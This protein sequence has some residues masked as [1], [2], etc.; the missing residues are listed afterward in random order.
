VLDVLFSAEH[1]LFL[2]HPILLFAAIG[3]VLFFRANPLL[4]GLLLAGFFSQIYLIASWSF[5]SQGDS[6]GG[7]MFISLL[8]VFAIGLAAF[9]QRVT[10]K[11]NTQVLSLVVSGVLVLWNFFFLIQYRLGFISMSGPYTIRELTIGKMEM[12][13]EIANR[14]F[15]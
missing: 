9:L 12:I 1:G 15:H 6:F 3:L 10:L 2:W 13:I 7:R 14:F 8:P 11:Y 5:W 4:G